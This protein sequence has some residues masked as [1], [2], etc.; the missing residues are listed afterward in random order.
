M[1]ELTLLT[2]DGCHLCDT[3]K[4]V[5]ARVGRQHPVVLNEIDISTRPDLE[6][7]FGHDI[8]VLL[9]GDRVIARHRISSS[10]LVGALSLSS[11]TAR[12]TKKGG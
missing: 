9:D 8:P 10:Q 3:M 4:T 6:R 7:Q 5:V 2:R 1:T 12:D 11:Q